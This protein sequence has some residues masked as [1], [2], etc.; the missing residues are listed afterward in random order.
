MKLTR[1]TNFQAGT[2]ARSSEING[3]FNQILNLLNGLL[4]DDNIADNSISPNKLNTP[5]ASNKFKGSVA[6]ETDLA[7]VVNPQHMDLI[8]VDENLA[9]YCYDKPTLK[10]KIIANVQT[11][12]SHNTLINRNAADA[13]PIVAITGLRGE[14]D[15]LR[16]DIDLLN[17]GE[18]EVPESI[19]L[20]LANHEERIVQL[21][22]DTNANG[23]LLA[24]HEDRLD[25]DEANIATLTSQMS[26]ANNTI[27]SHTTSIGTNA[28][29]VSG[30]K[31]RM[32]TAEGTIST[33]T[34]SIGT[35]STDIS[36]L[37]TRVTTL[38]GNKK[39]YSR[40]LNTKAVTTLPTGSVYTKVNIGDQ[41]VTIPGW[42]GTTNEYTVPETGLYRFYT[43]MVITGLTAETV[44]SVYMKMQVNANPDNFL[45]YK[46][47]KRA[48]TNLQGELEIY[49]N[50]ND[51]VSLLVASSTGGTIGISGWNTFN[52]RFI[53]TGTAPV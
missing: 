15:S 23:N 33:H 37:K 41:G 49:L 48:T 13:H 35:N 8:T 44:Q 29:D 30:L 3:E 22:S 9:L 6:K 25:T 17:A 46:H 47:T 42:N 26:T 34:T 12:P 51:K 19:G 1:L 4:G 38:E 40:S 53:T 20:T 45:T 27:A 31:T 28:T 32:T 24:N 36:G 52:V 43:S 11:A 21:E 16:F 10:W 39:P 50:A 7:T 18:N 14:L 5:L 2:V